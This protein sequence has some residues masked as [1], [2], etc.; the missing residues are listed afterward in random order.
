MKKALIIILL[1]ALFVFC[2]YMIYTKFDDIKALYVANRVDQTLT[3]M[4]E[5][6]AVVEKEEPTEDTSVADAIATAAAQATLQAEQTAAAVEPTEQP[7]EVPTEVPTPEPTIVPTIAS[8]DPGVYLGDADWTDE[9]DAPKNWPVG[10]DEFSSAYFEN[11]YYRMTSFAAEDGWR[12]AS[13]EAVVDGYIE[14]AFSTETCKADDHYGIMF[15][16]PVLKEANRGYLFGITCDGKY[17]LRAWDATLGENGTMEYLI[18]WKD[19]GT[20]NTGSEKKNVL[21]V[22]TSDDTLSLYING[23][24]VNEVSDDSI[25]GG[26]FGVFVGWEQTENL[27]VR[28]E[29]AGYWME[30]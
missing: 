26:Y 18:R 7:T 30:E 11:S 16:V 5:P 12:L 20:I 8:T 22:M 29:K 14:I 2:G 15:R 21:G 23:D 27:T 10:A 13:T 6:T 9:M 4:P 3:D 1:I 25:T 19:S 28:V 24:L 17:S